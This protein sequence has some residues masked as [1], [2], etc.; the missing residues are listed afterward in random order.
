MLTKGV[1]MFEMCGVR[2]V[3]GVRRVRGNR[4]SVG[5]VL[6]R[7]GAMHK[8]GKGKHEVVKDALTHDSVGFAELLADG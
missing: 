3:E 7:G 6:A 4:A 5:G 8:E 2:G 1:N